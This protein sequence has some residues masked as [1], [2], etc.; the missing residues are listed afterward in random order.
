MASASRDNVF[1]FDPTVRRPS[2]SPEA[3]SLA[4]GFG[5]QAPLQGAL[6]SQAE[7]H[8]LK[9]E[10][11]LRSPGQRSAGSPQHSVDKL[12]ATASQ[13]PL[14]DQERLLGAIVASLNSRW[15]SS[16]LAGHASLLA[17]LEALHRTAGTSG[18]DGHTALPIRLD[19]LERARR[20]AEALPDW[21]N[22][23]I[24]CEPDGEIAF[25]WQL[26][27]NHVV[28]VSIGLTDD[29]SYAA[30]FGRNKT[31]GTEQ[32]AGEIPR[33]IVACMAR[34]LAGSSEARGR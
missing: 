31:Y 10:R 16:P 22:P 17:S 29:L 23:E 9:L 34:L 26:D 28:S 3:S 2:C 8:R 25:E 13:L 4:A 7:A 21:P 30:M 33:P 6:P 15:G 20:F 24:V 14:A 5:Q 1:I 19:T 27:R 12:I 11:S 18:W 32:F